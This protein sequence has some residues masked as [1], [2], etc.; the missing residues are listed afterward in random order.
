MLTPWMYGHAGRDL[1]TDPVAQFQ[2]LAEG[3]SET[4]SQGNE[5][6]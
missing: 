4:R 2:E 3:S 6:A 5:V 1:Q